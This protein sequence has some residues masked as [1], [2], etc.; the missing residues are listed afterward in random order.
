[1][2]QISSGRKPFCEFNYDV[3]LALEIVEGKREVITNGTPVEYS[4]LY[5][6]K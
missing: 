2:W 6:G 4:N 1:M 3:S 5:E